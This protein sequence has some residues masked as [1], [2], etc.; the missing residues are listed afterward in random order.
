MKVLAI[1]DPHFRTDNVPE[2]EIFINKV[3]ELAKS[4]NPTW[5]V[6][7]GDVLHTHERIHTTPLNKAYEFVERM[8]NIAPT[9]VLVGN[10]DMTSN[11]NFLT[12]QHWMNGMKEWVDVTIVDKTISR[13]EGGKTFI[14]V[15]YVPPGRFSEAL[16]TIKDWE[17]ADCIFAHQ[18]FYG[19]KMGAIISA[20]GDSW[21]KDNP[22]IVSGH[23]HSRQTPQSNIYYCGSAMQ[24]AFGESEINIIPILTW[25]KNKKEYTLRE[26]DLGLSRKR[27]VYSDVQSINEVEIKK[28]DDKIKFSL[29]GDYEEFKAFKKTQK[30]REIVKSGT[31]VVFK[32][33]KVKQEDALKETYEEKDFFKILS[34]LIHNEKDPHLFRVYEKIVHGRENS[35]EELILY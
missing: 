32:P 35:D 10:H 29:T 5:I 21:S 34:S 27:I 25:G 2:V 17:K 6:I 15:P 1:G 31:K 23:I 4:E 14:F 26:V 3:E 11:Q 24:H 13:T 12:D 16:D 8:R 9:F 30:Y 7:L 28:T 22:P 19:C 18:E 20:E 33:K